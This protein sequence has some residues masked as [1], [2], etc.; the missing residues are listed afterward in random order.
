MR[1]RPIRAT[2]QPAF[3]FDD[4]L[5]NVL[6]RL[7]PKPCIAAIAATAISA[8]IRPYSMAVAPREFLRSA[9]I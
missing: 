9:V 4:A 8:A 7:L 2:A 3:M 1:G 6:L 5:L